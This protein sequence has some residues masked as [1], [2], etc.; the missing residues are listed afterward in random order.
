MGDF[1]AKIG[2]RNEDYEE[3]MGKHGVEKRNGNGEMFVETC[4]NNKLVI[5]GRGSEGPWKMSE[6][7]EEQMQ[8]LT[9]ICW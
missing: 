3:V 6:P 2:G 1:N 7:E 5:G 8:H 4:V 9:T